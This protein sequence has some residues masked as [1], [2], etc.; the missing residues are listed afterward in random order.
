M[1]DDSL[2]DT[3]PLSAEQLASRPPLPRDD[4]A[5]ILRLERLGD[6]R[7]LSLI[8]QGGMGSVYLAEQDHPL[9]KVA[10][11]LMRLGGHDTESEQRFLREGAT[12]ARLDHPGIA[13]V[14]AAGVAD[15]MLGKLPYFAMEFVDGTNLVAHATARKLDTA[16]RL[17]LMVKISSAVQHAHQR[18][19]VHRDLKPANILVDADG[20]PRVLDFG[21]ARLIDEAESST[22]LTQMGELVGTLPYMSPE[23]LQGDPSAVDTRADVYALGVILY[24]LLA[25][26]LPREFEPNTS[27]VQAISGA[28]QLRLLPLAKANPACKGE[29]DIITMKALAE[30]PAQRYASASELGA[31]IERY[32]RDEP[33][34]ARPPS[35]WY[36]TRK[37]AR[38][39]RG[40]VAA[41]MIVALTLV[42]STVFALDAAWKEREARQAADVARQ[43]ADQ[44]RKGA[45]RSAAISSSVQGFTNDMLMA[46][47]P[48]S[49]LG[50]EVSVREVVDQASLLLRHSPP[51]DPMVAAE[52]ALALASVNLALGRFAPAQ[53]LVGDARKQLAGAGAEAD[54]TR[55]DAAILDI[56]VR[57]AIGADETTEQ[58]A[59]ALVAT[60]GKTLGPKDP[61][62]FDASNLLGENLMRQSKF[63][64]ANL[65]FRQVL[66]A[67]IRLLP[68]GRD[69]R[70]T[71]LANLAVSLRGAG[72][73]KG[74]A[75][76]LAALEKEMSLRRGA[77]HPATLS[78]VNNLAIALQNSGD[79]A[80]ALALYDR[81][82]AGRSRVLGPDHPDTLNVLQNRA[83]LLIQA[84]KAREAEPQLRQLLAT[85]LK[86]RQENHP[87]VLVAMNSLAYALED[88][89]RL[90]EAEQI[91]RDTLAIQLQAKTAH[92]ETFGTRNNLAMLLMRE[93]KLTAAEDEFRQIV[94]L[95]TEHL[96][97]EH[98][99]VMIFSNN[100][101]ECLTRMKRYAEAEALLLRTHAALA[102]SMGDDNARTAKARTRLAELY[103]RMQRPDSA[104]KWRKSAAG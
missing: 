48:E 64:E 1:A 95:A 88:I 3:I 38:R 24:E 18:G 41:T 68:A 92:P 22:R 19:V 102:K 35:A 7:L 55:M 80:Q 101:G 70:E 90:P 14:H 85:L 33:I 61:R 103:D 32:L 20:H 76:V 77:D 44:A 45:E 23:Q 65:Q 60:I 21:I 86:T 9:R 26:R 83:T 28:S 53:E 46:A 40:L 73:T 84:G 30:D 17:Q 42:G 89:G 29:L 87:A 37:F 25:G 82:F 39:H 2:H 57:T 47:M 98:P 67:P 72:D 81:A 5:A 10:I 74:A 93:G 27:L 8:G 99:Y 15:T 6:F 16:A 96:G 13:K 34:L 97:A 4:Q 94:A 49:A 91:Y 104:A 63:D 36:V 12:L 62:N 78:V 75:S 50:R 66:N 11:K 79:A 51:R 100:Y 71:A 56:R 54:S 58:D 31:D 52:S 69:A 59:R 43:S